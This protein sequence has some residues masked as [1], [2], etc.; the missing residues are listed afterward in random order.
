MNEEK[1]NLVVKE[2]LVKPRPILEEIPRTDYQQ[3]LSEL[4]TGHKNKKYFRIGIAAIGSIPWLGSWITAAASLS[5]TVMNATGEEDQDKTNVLLA[6]WVSE[7]ESKIKEFILTLRDIYSRFDNFGDEIKERLES[8]EYLALVRKAFQS[9]DQADTEEKRQMY[10]RL[11]IS[12]GATTLCPDDL[13]KLFIGWIDR[14]HEA[15]FVVMKEIYQ[16]PGTTRGK[17]WD[18]VHGDRPRDDSPEAGLFGYLTRELSMA[19]I[20]HQETETNYLGQALKRQR[21][22]QSYQA[23]ASRIKE[24]PFEDTKPYQLTPLGKEFVHYVMK[25]VATQIGEQKN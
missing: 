3:A 13:I 22:K 1:N 9:W 21:P 20:V 18:K 12:A 8:P 23:P 11:L 19:G 5:S 2:V 7:H 4:I 24:S 17:I 15:H 16:S 25:D 6:L 10:K 14:Y